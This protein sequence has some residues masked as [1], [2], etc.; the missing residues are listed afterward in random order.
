M[1]DCEVAQRDEFADVFLATHLHHVQ[2]TVFPSLSLINHLATVMPLA[3]SLRSNVSS[4]ADTT[5]PF[6]T[7][8]GKKCSTTKRRHI[9]D[10]ST[11]PEYVASTALVSAVTATAE[12]A[13]MRK[14]P[15][16]RQ[17]QRRSASGQQD[18]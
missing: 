10:S 9:G 6:S 5:S 7:V 3:P 8:T 14:S 2:P 1:A 4:I 17:S 12:R 16:A 11:V 18:R 15:D 13:M